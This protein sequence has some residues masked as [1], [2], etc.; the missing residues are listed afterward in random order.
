LNG[1]LDK[2]PG[3]NPVY[4]VSRVMPRRLQ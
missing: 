2:L 4:R 3:N 1:P